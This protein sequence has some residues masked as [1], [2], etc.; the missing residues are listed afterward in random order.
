MPG[1]RILPGA[2]PVDL[3]A[4]GLRYMESLPAILSS[5]SRFT[6]K[7]PINM[8]FVPEILAA[9]PKARGICLRRHPA[10]SVLSIYRQLFPA[11]A[12]CCRVAP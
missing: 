9:L 1:A 10:D 4:A 2:A 8:L 11:G 7:M 6:D 3:S 5:P 12:G